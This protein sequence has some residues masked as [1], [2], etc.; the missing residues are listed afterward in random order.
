MLLSKVGMPA[1]FPVA[2][3]EDKSIP[4]VSGSEKLPS[5]SNRSGTLDAVILIALPLHLQSRVKKAVHP[6]T[7]SPIRANQEEPPFVKDRAGHR[8]VRVDAAAERARHELPSACQIVGA[9]VL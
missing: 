9:Q 8:I 5:F 7:E 4:A 3:V 1:F 6:N 2:Q